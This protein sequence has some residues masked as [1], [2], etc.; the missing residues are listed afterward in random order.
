MIVTKTS[1]IICM[2][3]S[4]DRFPE[5][6]RIDWKRM[7]ETT[8]HHVAKPFFPSGGGV[9]EWGTSL[10]VKVVYGCSTRDFESGPKKRCK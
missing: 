4:R 2:Y 9:G 3:K 8:V 1:F 5:I 10:E 7:R 6:G